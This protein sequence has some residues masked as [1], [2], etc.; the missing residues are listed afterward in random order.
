LVLVGAFAVLRAWTPTNIGGTPLANN[1][2]PEMNPSV[3][4]FKAPDNTNQRT[5]NH[6]D[7]APLP[8]E[9]QDPTSAK[10]DELYAQELK[11]EQEQAARR[12]PDEWKRAIASVRTS[13]GQ[14]KHGPTPYVQVAMDVQS[15]SAAQERLINWA[16][17]VKA[18][19]KLLPSEAAA[20][21]SVGL[22]LTIAPASST[23]LL[24][25]LKSV[26]SISELTNNNVLHKAQY[27]VHPAAPGVPQPQPNNGPFAKYMPIDPDIARPNG[28]G[29]KS[30]NTAA[31]A[32]GSITVVVMLTPTLLSRN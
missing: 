19:A 27:M 8:I 15:V 10:A 1:D 16:Q 21:Q 25:K 9:A 31:P 13:A 26:G 20:H 4:L 18:V 14:D 6:D 17:S 22:V 23:A 12:L 11:K 30:T 5:D 24:N 32:P 7:S 3:N 29:A 28:A 2:G